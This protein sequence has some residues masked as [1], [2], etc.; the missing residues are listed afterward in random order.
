[1]IEWQPIPKEIRSKK[2]LAAL[3]MLRE[4][5]KRTYEPLAFVD[6]YTRMG[7]TKAHFR[8]DIRRHKGFREELRKMGLQEAEHPSGQ[9]YWAFELTFRAYDFGFEDETVDT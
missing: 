8:S 9:G 4:H 1:V 6:I 3:D 2:V 5:F 7:M